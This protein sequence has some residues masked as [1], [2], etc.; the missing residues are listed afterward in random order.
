M[1]GSQTLC[2]VLA[3]STPVHLSLP[4]TLADADRLN[5][6]PT[7]S[8]EPPSSLALLSPFSRSVLSLSSAQSDETN[9][10]RGVMMPGVCSGSHPGWKSD[11]GSP[12]PA[13]LSTVSKVCVGDVVCLRPVSTGS[14]DLSYTWLC[15][16]ALCRL[17]ICAEGD[18]D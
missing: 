17:A 9:L 2:P 11:R 16:S 6:F 1:T 15:L 3:G 5:L 7:F 10:R 12:W 13:L 18:T 8:S 4:P 14:P